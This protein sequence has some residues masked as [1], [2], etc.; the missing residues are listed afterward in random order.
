MSSLLS[1]TLLLPFFYAFAKKK[2]RVFNFCWF[3]GRF[4]KLRNYSFQSRKVFSS[5]FFIVW[6]LLSVV[7]SFFGWNQQKSQRNINHFHHNNKINYVKSSGP[8]FGLV[9]GL[10]KLLN[11]NAKQN[12]AES[13]KNTQKWMM[14]LCWPQAKNEEEWLTNVPVKN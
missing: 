7:S 9:F 5:S 11:A 12:K 3:V 1:L 13:E 8:I 10:M 4:I 6:T 14:K 2:N